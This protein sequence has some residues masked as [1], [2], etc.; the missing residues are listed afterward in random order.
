MLS[1][2][3]PPLRLSPAN[4]ETAAANFLNPQNLSLTLSDKIKAKSQILPL[5]IWIGVDMKDCKTKLF[6]CFLLVG[7]GCYLC[8]SSQVCGVVIVCGDTEI[9]KME[10]DRTMIGLTCGV[11]VCL[12]P[13]LLQSS[14][15]LLGEY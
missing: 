2:R 15:P 5:N 11:F 7:G 14:S 1:A 8:P 6:D 9:V 12:R 4:T 3:L 10:G 13:T